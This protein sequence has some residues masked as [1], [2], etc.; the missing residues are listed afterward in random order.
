MQCA[1]FAALK[2]A[3]PLAVQFSSRQSPSASA[4][5]HSATA[6]ALGSTAQHVLRKGVVRQERN[7]GSVRSTRTR[8]WLRQR[9]PVR[10]LAAEL[11]LSLSLLLSALLLSSHV[12][13]GRSCDASCAQA[14]SGGGG[15]REDVVSALAPRPEL[16]DECAR[17]RT[18]LQLPAA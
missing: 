5:S 10:R 3:K 14:T 7:V 15:H 18:A 16:E 4:H 13:D 9:A 11:S 2:A 6:T 1:I 8:R 17:V 12:M